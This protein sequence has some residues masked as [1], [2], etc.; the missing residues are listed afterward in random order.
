MAP[1]DDDRYNAAGLDGFTSSIM[2]LVLGMFG[3]LTVIS[4]DPEVVVVS[5]RETVRKL[6][7]EL[8]LFALEL[9]LEGNLGEDISERLIFTGG[10]RC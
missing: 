5:E 9:L 4:C 2:K 10:A 1:V 3:L 7:L 8:P 6:V